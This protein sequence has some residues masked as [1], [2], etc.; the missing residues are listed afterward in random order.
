MGRTVDLDQQP[1]FEACEIHNERTDRRLSAEM[2]PFEGQSFERPPQTNLGG[3]FVGAQAPR[4]CTSKLSDCTPTR[5][6]PPPAASRRPSP[7]RGGSNARSHTSCLP[8]A[9]MIVP[10]STAA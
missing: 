2:G 1:L 4:G 6:S 5:H 3:R 7:S 9:S 10:M 8:F